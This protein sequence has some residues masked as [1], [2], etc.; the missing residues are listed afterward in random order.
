MAPFS[1]ILKGI[2]GVGLLFF[3]LLPARA[4]TDNLELIQSLKGYWAF[5]IGIDDDWLKPEYNDSK[6]E[7]IRVPS[8]WE[9]QGFNGY[10]GYACYR[11]KVTIP[12]SRQGQMLYLYLGYIDDVD[13][14]YLNGQLLGSMG[15]FPPTFHTAYNAERIYLIPDNLIR[16]N[17]EN[18]IV[19][20][21]YD[22]QQEGGIVRG[23]VGIY[24]GKSSMR[25]D[26]SF[27]NQ[28]KFMTGDNLNWKNPDFD[29]S[30]WYDILVPSIW[31]NRGFRD[32][33]GYAWYRK[34][35]VYQGV[36]EDRMVLILGKIDD[37]DQVYLNGKL[38]GAT[39]NLTNQARARVGTSDEYRAFRGYFLPIGTLKKGQKYV[40][41]IRVL[42]NGGEGGIYE[43]PVGIITQTKYI[44]YWR[45]NR[46]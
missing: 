19:V 33:D 25:L 13:A 16:Y 42:D 29:D 1:N 30:K 32:Y 10:N 22:V 31:E 39:G 27:N 26:F 28:W 5:S 38:V 21:V 20:K 6:W 17:Q 2:C 23:D 43:G 7:S 41:A 11:K 8:P 46:K 15:D 44:E 40:I 35:F 45:K 36:A 12:A 3:G 14:V 9:D 37:A 34:T 24:G 4:V 18:V